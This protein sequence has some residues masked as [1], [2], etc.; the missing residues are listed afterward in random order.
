MKNFTFLKNV[1]L[2]IFLVPLSIY[3]QVH[4][5][6][7]CGVNYSLEWSSAPIASNEY[8]WS[9]AGALTS[10]YTN[11]DNS[12]ID[13]TVAFTGDTSSFGAWTGTTTPV[14][15]NDSSPS[16][17]S[18][19]LFTNGY[20][21]SGITCTITFSS[22]IYALSFDINHINTSSVN[23]DKYTVSGTNTNG[24]TI[25]PTF[26]S[27][28]SPSYT[29]NDSTGII[30]A[31]GASVAGNDGIV[32]VNFSDNDYI[33]SVTFL[34]QD[35][36]TCSPG[37]V[38]G[39]GL[40]SFSFCIPQTLDFDGNNDY[41]DRTAFLGNKS[42]ATMMSW[43]KLKSGFDGGDV[44][45]QKNYRLFIDNTN[46]IQCEVETGTPPLVDY[47]LNM[48]DSYGDGWTNKGVLITVNGTPLNSGLPFTVT[49]Q[50]VTNT[51]ISASEN[52][53][54][55]V[56]DIIEITY[57]TDSFAS[58]MSWDLV[59]INDNAN[60]ITNHTFS[61]NNGTEI[62]PNI[63]V[64][65]SS[66]TGGTIVTTSSSTYSPIL[67]E[68]LWYH[69]ASTYD[70]TTGE[71]KLYLNGELLDTRTGIASTLSPNSGDFEIGRNPLST[72]NYFEGS[73][74]ETKVYK[75]ALTENQLRKQIYQ[76]VENNSG[77]IMGAII[78][79]NI[80]GLLWSDLELY[81]KMGV[82]ETGH[83]PDASDSGIDGNLNN[84][85]T[86][87]ERTAPLPY[88]TTSGGDGNWSNSNNWLHGD[89]WDISYSHP[90]WAIVKIADNIQTDTS[91]NT[92]GLFI[93]NTKK[94]S[95]NND[96]ELNISWYLKLDG[97]IDLEGESQLVQGSNSELDATSSGI[98]EIDQQGTQD[99]Y[100][101]NY[102][103]SPVGTSNN[104]TNN[105]SYTIP[106]IL[107]DGT[108]SSNPLDIYFI[109][110]GYDGNPGPP[111]CIADYWIWKYSN[112]ANSYYNW[113]HVRSTGNILAGEGFTMK[114]VNDT[115]G[116]VSLEQNYTLTGKPNNSVITLPITAGNSYLVGNPYASAID[117]HQ[118]IMDNAPVI[119][120][121]G[122][123]NG[124]LYFWE[125]WGG[126]THVT[127]DYQGGYATYNLS[128][129][130][131]AAALGTNTL[132]SG[133]TP[134]KLPGRYIPVAQGFFVSGEATGNIIFNNGQRIFQ[135]EGA[136]SVFVKN[137]VNASTNN[138]PSTEDNRMKIRLGFNS[139]NTII[140]Q[141]L[142]TVDENASLTFDYGYDGKQTETQMDDMYWMISDEKCVIQGI[143]AIETT[144]I[145]PLGVH[146]NLDGLNTFKIDEL[147]NVPPDL[148]IYIYDTI[149]ETYH[150][151]RQ[152]NLSIHLD[153]GEYLNRFE[154]RFTN[155]NVLSTGHF[156][157]IDGIQFFFANNN[158]TIIV[159]NPKLEVIKSV[160][161][162]N[163]LRQSI[164]K[165]DN[166]KTQNHIE[167][168]TNA[169]NT[170][171]YIL[172]V[173]T[174]T[175]KFSKKV[176]I[177]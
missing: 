58:E 57:T 52:F 143:D 28:S 35:C 14:V 72:N 84:M 159:K 89:V 13:F 4:T 75:K 114:G 17:Q 156:E 23:G 164:I 135:K 155:D 45:G 160:E 76:E 79:K 51:P 99:L 78:P 88:I 145:L 139:V 26:T 53:S 93:E 161:L 95:I 129:S 134:T 18:L 59:N 63:I 80:D 172:E 10:T 133:G 37:N 97:K 15:G 109:T 170:G 107:K 168:E 154:L 167:L 98:I 3:C 144:S 83:T 165:F 141:I 21:S 70:G 46:K 54:A 66:C 148:E 162:Y 138:N 142:V 136:N 16:Y 122:A 151:I 102:W 22:P 82:I 67:S 43:I 166:L 128:G 8:N 40:G 94:L 140:R 131:P 121:T 96:S 85:R 9:S 104:S 91:H 41:I 71:M 74:Y 49:N 1:V 175:G 36:D 48:Y 32:G 24:D 20:S 120:T 146:T 90:D 31:T 124:S 111:I 105:N 132:G 112:D 171:N 130:V 177:E 5:P 68:N 64:S 86:Y 65:C 34:W 137:G 73:I 103:S 61:T 106:D 29:A 157:E 163:V 174:K 77:H 6:P 113:Q 81:Y 150:D 126:G 123:T 153:A 19:D 147:S 47:Q 12:G 158:E 127:A 116:N 27:S 108:N 100:T 117:A 101:Y 149:T 39:S 38:H 7:S 92:L 11:V 169:I 69:V 119:E 50:G 62:L 30:N 176:L 125:H 60:V 25:L 44:M 152:S 87:Q 56:D 110:N 118:F 2:Y 55:N 42:E 173:K 115:G 33:T